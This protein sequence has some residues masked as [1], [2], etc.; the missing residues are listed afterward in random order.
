MEGGVGVLGGGGTTN[1]KNNINPAL[2]EGSGFGIHGGVPGLPF[3]HQ[4]G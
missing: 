3:K 2:G 1:C 4:V